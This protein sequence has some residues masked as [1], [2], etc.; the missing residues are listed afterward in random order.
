MK[1]KTLL[2]VFILVAFMATGLVA[3]VDKGQLGIMLPTKHGQ[4]SEVLPISKKEYQ[5][6][7]ANEI[8]VRDLMLAKTNGIV[9]TIKTPIEYT[10]R[11]GAGQGDTMASYFKPPAALIVKSIGMIFSDIDDGDGEC[12]TVNLSLAKSN[13]ALENHPADSV[14][15]VGWIGAFYETNVFSSSSWGV[16]PL[17]WE[18]GNLPLWGDFPVTI[19]ATHEWVFTDMIFLGLEP[20]VGRDSFWAVMVPVGDPGVFIRWRSGDATGMPQWYGL[21]CYPHIPEGAGGPGAEGGWYI[22]HYGWEVYAV[23]EFY[24]NTPPNLA[25]TG[26]YGTVLDDAAR[27]V[28][29]S[30]SDIDANDPN[31]AGAETVTMHYKVN[32][33]ADWTDVAATLASGTA[34]DGI[35]EGVIPAG[36]LTPGDVVTFKF[37][38]TDFAGLV[39][40][41]GTTSYGYF[42]KEND[43]LVFYNDDGTSYPSW[44]L[45]PY[46]D[47]LWL[48]DGG[49]KYPYDVWV[50]LEDGA[51]NAELINMYDN[52]VQIDAYSP[53]TDP[54]VNDAVLGPWFASGAKNMFYSS[55]EYAGALLG[56]WSAEDDTT[57]AADDWHNMYLGIGYLGGDGHDIGADPLAV[58]PVEGD[59]LSG[60]LY[61]FLGDSLQLY[62]NTSYE[63][64]WTNWSDAVQA[65]EGAVVSFTDS[66]MGRT[67]GV[68]KQEGSYHGA[69]LGFDQ[70]CL[71]TGPLAS[72]AGPG[73]WWTEP[74][75]SSVVGNFL[76]WAGVTSDVEDNVQPGVAAKYNLSQNYPNP[77]NPETRIT[78]SIS[79]PGMVKLA[80]YNVLGQK[81][82]EIVNERQVANTYKVTF[83]ASNLTSG[84]Y[85]YRLEVGDYSKTMKMML[86]R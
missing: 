63:L 72:Y 31:Q 65:G 55:Q 34:E 80:V 51:L 39:G 2:V 4:D 44:I 82:A 12:H 84:V 50:G 52:M 19:T 46:Y 61:D 30:V 62:I 32:D 59:P 40:E 9:D 43:I 24:E 42:A 27:T 48:D 25:I 83:D 21:K 28:T 10:V 78:Y 69:F 26:S 60:D 3:K 33:A 56:G 73:Y 45:S 18:P 14:D 57:F 20:D 68:H 70:L 7:K 1:H 74:N 85:F 5:A 11:F 71:D 64:G 53:A 66:A 81:V 67:M 15:G 8:T 86:L 79:K 41:S 23:V 75:V 38:A 47:N 16:Y 17:N 54:A 29:C 22:R 13:Y 49:N 77:F 76:R 35:W 6:L 58:N 37:S 36:I